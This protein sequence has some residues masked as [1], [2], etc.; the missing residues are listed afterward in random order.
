MVRGIPS[1]KAQSGGGMSDQRECARRYCEVMFTPKKPDQKYCSR[2]CAFKQLYFS[3]HND[4]WHDIN[5][6]RG[7]KYSG[8]RYNKE[9]T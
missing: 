8:A 4:I 3:R 5:E 9:R 7:G 6:D 1:L 2:R